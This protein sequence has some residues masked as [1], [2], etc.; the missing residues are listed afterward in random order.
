[1]GQE[2]TKAVFTPPPPS[3]DDTLEGL[4]WIPSIVSTAVSTAA[5]RQ[6]TEAAPPIPTV[7]LDWKGANDERSLPPSLSLFACNA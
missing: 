3:Y 5:S 7:F 2:L 1:M 6:P 4:A